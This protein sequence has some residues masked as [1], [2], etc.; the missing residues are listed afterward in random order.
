MMLIMSLRVDHFEG[1]LIVKVQSSNPLH[2]SGGKWYKFIL[3]NTSLSHQCRLF[4]FGTN[5]WMGD[6]MVPSV[7]ISVSYNSN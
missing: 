3:L 6:R 1:D 4:A 7:T 2:S 5:T